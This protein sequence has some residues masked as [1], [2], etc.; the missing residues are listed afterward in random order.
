MVA[1]PRKY[2]TYTCKEDGQTFSRPTDYA[3][4][5]KLRHKRVKAQ[6]L[7]NDQGETIEEQPNKPR[8]I[9]DRA[10]QTVFSSSPHEW[11]EWNHS[12]LEQ[13]KHQQEIIA[14]WEQ[15]VADAART[16]KFLEAD[17]KRLQNNWE[18]LQVAKIQNEQA[19]AYQDYA[20]GR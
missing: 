1:K 4:H 6:Q 11:V 3:Q 14:T 8:L 16:I 18:K 17:N 20:K 2:G 19:V 10:T 9:P 15:A 12:L 5:I 7:F 13:I